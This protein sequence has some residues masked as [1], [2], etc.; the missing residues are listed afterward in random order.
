MRMLAD[1][2]SFIR[3]YFALSSPSELSGL[4][5]IV[6]LLS[7][8]VHTNHYCGERA[9]SAA[10]H[11]FFCKLRSFPFPSHGGL[12]TTLPRQVESFPSERIQAIHNVSGSF[13]VSLRDVGEQIAQASS[14]QGV[15]SYEMASSYDWRDLQFIVRLG[16]CVK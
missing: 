1:A 5:A 16:A 15:L 14:L 10:C 12:Q 13:P 9:V 4:M 7:L 8:E 11:L 2:F 3:N 6:T